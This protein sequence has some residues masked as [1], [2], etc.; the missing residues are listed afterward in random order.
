M[1]PGMKGPF[2]C[3]IGKL[4]ASC[5][6]LFDRV[7]L[8]ATRRWASSCWDNTHKYRKSSCGRHTVQ[9]H[10]TTYFTSLT[11]ITYIIHHMFRLWMLNVCLTALHLF[12]HLAVSFSSNSSNGSGRKEKGTLPK[13]N[14][15]ELPIC[16]LNYHKDSQTRCQR[17]CVI[18]FS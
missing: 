13:R 7:Q 17:M 6:L 11:Y 5:F 1:V 9:P 12:G 2:D 16:S 8:Q 3:R 4:L 18:S 10:Y 14:S 15:K